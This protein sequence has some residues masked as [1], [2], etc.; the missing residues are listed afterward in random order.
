MNEPKTEVLELAEKL[1]RC[2]SV[3]PNEAGCYDIVRKELAGCGFHFEAIDRNETKNLWITRP[4]TGK[5][6]VFAGHVD[7]VPPGDASLW[8]H[9]PF[10]PTVDGGHLYARGAQDMKSSVA[11]FIVA[12]KRFLAAHPKTDASIALLLTSDEEGEATDGT[13]YVLEVLEKRPEIR[14]AWCIVGEPTCSKTFGDAVKNGRRGSINTY[15][16][17]HGIQGHVA[18]PEKVRNPIHIASKIVAELA[19]TKFGSE[20]PAFPLSSFEVSNF[21]AGT[22]A[23]NVVPADCNVVF[24]I[25]FNPTVTAEELKVQIEDVV[26][27]YTSDYSIRF[28]CSAHPFCTEGETLLNA[29]CRAAESVCGARP[30]LSTSGGTSDARFIAKW[31]PEVAEFGPVN[32]FIHKVNENIEL[33]ELEGLTEIYCRMLTEL[34]IR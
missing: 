23:V 3:T 26:R 18:Y 31:C 17:V 8:K 22:G 13:P 30:A 16:T 2:P 20:H 25:R 21:N 12:V 15:L 7:V 34:Y 24:N 19:D 5:L 28:T 9:P 32:S 29:V 11:C 27:R 1:L 33:S 14:P 10:E 6:F 4:G